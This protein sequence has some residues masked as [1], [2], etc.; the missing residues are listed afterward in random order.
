MRELAVRQ[1][2][3]ITMVWTHAACHHV[4]LRHPFDDSLGINRCDCNCSHARALARVFPPTYL[5]SS[6]HVPAAA[7]WNSSRRSD[8]WRPPLLLFWMLLRVPSMAV[9]RAQV[10]H[11]NFGWPGHSRLRDSLRR[12]RMRCTSGRLRTTNCSRMTPRAVGAAKVQSCSVL[13]TA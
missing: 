4:W 2:W 12:L 5:T 8:S 3:D 13:T 6:G 1:I 10:V 9:V 11:G 7:V